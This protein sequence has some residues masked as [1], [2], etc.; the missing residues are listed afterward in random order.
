M[1][2]EFKVPWYYP[3]TVHNRE[4]GG[5]Q[6]GLG[7]SPQGAWC[8]CVFISMCKHVLRVWVCVQ[9]PE[10]AW[11][12]MVSRWL[13]LAECASDC[14]SACVS[15]EGGCW[16]QHMSFSG[17]LQCGVEQSRRNKE[18]DEGWRLRE[19]SESKT[20]LLL[21]TDVHYWVNRTE[22]LFGQNGVL[23]ENT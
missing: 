14:L 2:N 8:A 23:H 9:W 11:V 18:R 4:G 21:N 12:C 20:Q 6:G 10:A 3:S 7:F 17:A 13:G 1:Y 16:C 19:Y 22:W 15:V 5:C